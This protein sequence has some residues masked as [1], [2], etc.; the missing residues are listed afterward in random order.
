MG[1]VCGFTCQQCQT[2]FIGA[3]VQIFINSRGPFC[4]DCVSLG[5]TYAGDWEVSDG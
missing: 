2:H 5:V 4:Q 1:T 3:Y